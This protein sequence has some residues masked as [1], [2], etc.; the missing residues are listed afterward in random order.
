MRIRTH[1]M[2]AA[3]D[4][5]DSSTPV[6]FFQISRR[7]VQI[8]LHSLPHSASLGYLSQEIHYRQGGRYR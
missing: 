7:N 6:V 2:C 1:V 3:C 8:P 5:V 4:A